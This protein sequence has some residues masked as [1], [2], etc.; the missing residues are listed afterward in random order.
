MMAWY[1]N[2]IFYQIYLRA[3]RD[4]D[5]NGHGDFAGLR[6]KA[7]YLKWLGIDCVWLMP[8]YPS[9][10]NDDGYDIASF[11]SIHHDFGL[12][13]DFRMTVDELHRH[14]IRLICDLVVN[15][16]SDEHPWFIE[17]RRSKDSPMRDF[18]VWSDTDDKYNETRI[19][20]L[21]TEESNWAYDEESQQ[22]YWHRFYSSQPDLN[23][24]NLA[25]QD[26]MLN[27]IKFWMDLG[28]DGF[29]VDAVPYLFER[30]GTNCENLPE[31]HAYLKKM[32]QFV[33]ENY[34]DSMFL[35]EA[36]QW[37]KDLLPYF[38]DDTGD[39]FHL[40][41]HFPIMPRLYMALAKKD[42]SSVVD[43][44]ADTPPI[45]ENAQW[46]TFLRNHDELTLEMVTEEERRFMWDYYSPDPN[47]RINLGIRR[48]LAPLMGNDRRKIEVM[49][50][51]LFT[52]PGTPVLYYGDEI[53]MGD[54]IQLFDRNGVRTPMQWDDSHNA[55][56]SS[57]ATDSLYAP[58][59]SDS[60]YG[61]HTVN[62]AAKRADKNSMLYTIR[63]MISRRKTMDFVAKAELVW[64]SDLPNHLLCFWRESDNQ[65]LL[66]LHNLSDEAVTIDLPKN[67]ESY[68]DA[69]W[70][71]KP[72][73][74]STITLAPYG[75]RWL[76][77]IS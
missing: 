71:G 59:I 54:N 26:E 62:V 76:L 35:G 43:V 19:I 48:R 58:P 4:S 73:E 6:E 77:P 20:F 7:E 60:E 11:Y 8:I 27:I 51:M 24:D 1:T 28:I 31:T 41:F 72:V 44:L 10:L 15:H 18:Y 45:P 65:K 47:Q 67:V 40:C 42:R 68:S 52:L 39:E 37:A 9:P 12:L 13:E 29:R 56:F 25:V 61:Y 33:D 70:T 46:A 23:Y 21:D 57:A 32:R 50:S 30:E 5:G 2:A 34:P 22:Y 36:N 17:A 63:Q 38:G 14:G 75:Y 74:N 55:G 66:A 53:G 3:F 49:N 69:L 64:L 16:T